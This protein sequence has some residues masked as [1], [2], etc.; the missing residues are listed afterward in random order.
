MTI[1]EN[2]WLTVI[3]VPFSWLYG[4]IMW[5]RNKFYDWGFFTSYRVRARVICVG[6]LTVGGTGKTPVV[7]A[8]A[9]L[10][11]QETKKT[12]VILSRGYRRET[13][14]TVIVS[15]GKQVLVAVKEAGDE[16]FM[17]AHR[18]KTVP[19]ICDEDRVR[20]AQIAIKQ[21]QADYV[22]LDDGFQHRRLRRDVDLMV[23]NAAHGFGNRHLLPA[24]P[25]RERLSGMHRAQ[26]IIINN[27]TDLSVAVYRKKYL[28]DFSGLVT[29]THYRPNRLVA[30][31]GDMEISLTDLSRYRIMGFSGI[32]NPE[33]FYQTLQ[34]LHIKAAAFE[35]FPDHHDFSIADFDFINQK[36]QECG[37]E[38]LITTEKDAVRLPG[39]SA[40]KKPVFYLE[41]ALELH[42]HSRILQLIHG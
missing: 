16:P 14:G 26:A 22:I 40:F 5:A 11:E 37:A 29:S 33:R 36:S 12:V 10:I 30:V 21:F 18:L 6:N 17:I 15:D 35:C 4:L 13:T 24:G 2:K 32:A 23:M 42:S 31:Y 20:G 19:V 25:L 38:I 28:P 34:G 27:L 41:M 3:L 8:L 9:H 7:A 1:F 39:E